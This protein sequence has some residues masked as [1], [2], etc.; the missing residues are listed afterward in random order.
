MF[1]DGSYTPLLLRRDLYQV[2]AGLHASGC[3]HVQPSA[4]DDALARQLSHKVINSRKPVAS[5][6]LLRNRNRSG[7]DSNQE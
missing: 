1:V 3:I 2:N 6:Q 5:P 4:F 7:T